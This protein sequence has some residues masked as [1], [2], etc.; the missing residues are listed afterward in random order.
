MPQFGPG[1][2]KTARVPMTNPTAKA[3]DYVAD[4]YMGTNLALMAETPFH[5]DAQESKDISLPVTM[6]TV[7]G[8]YP[9]H[10]GVFSGGVNI[11]LYRATEDV[12]IISVADRWV[13][14]TGYNDPD[15]KWVYEAKACDGDF[16]SWA[17]NYMADYGHYVEYLVEPSLSCSKVRIYA[18]GYAHYLHL[19]PHID[20]DLDYNGGWHNIFRGYISWGTWVE[21]SIPAGMKVVSKARIKS[22]L[23]DAHFR[24][25][26]FEF[27][28]H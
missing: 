2:L 24:L 15:N 1:E 27:W 14:P 11:G 26:E 18:A 17:G 8:T 6:P 21:I 20:I 4:L 10:I 19:N 13:S 16:Y 9:V 25:Y 23:S 12:V 5:L 3:F 28:G 7:A 22:N